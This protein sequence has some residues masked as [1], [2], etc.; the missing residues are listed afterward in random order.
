MINIHINGKKPLILIDG[1][2]YV[3]NRYFATYKWFMFQKKEIDIE[4]ILEN[5]EY[6]EAF[7]KHLESDFKKIQKKLKTDLNNIIICMDCLRYNIWRNEIYPEYKATRNT[8]TNFNKDIFKIFNEKIKELRIMKISLDKL[9][10]DDMIY[11]LQN[12]INE[13]NNNQNIIIITNDNDYLQ[14]SKK[15]L[16]IINMQF[17]DICLRGTLNPKIDLLLKIIHGDKSDNISKILQGLSK[18]KALKIALMEESDRIKYLIE[19]KAIE[20]Y[21]LN[22]KLISFDYIPIELIELFNNYYNI[23]II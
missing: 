11:L 5:E 13:L 17:K 18:E 9:E 14:L 1:S 21:E 6:I 22:K 7:N 23:S 15:N 8:K 2:Y 4:K 19:N 20:K 16:K 10:G 12:K 3:F